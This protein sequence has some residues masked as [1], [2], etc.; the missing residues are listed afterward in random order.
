MIKTLNSHVHLGN[1]EVEF[2]YKNPSI[3]DA[4][5]FIEKILT[6]VFRFSRNPHCSKPETVINFEVVQ[7]KS[8]SFFILDR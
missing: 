1:S 3:S 2:S 8:E 4:S 6:Q 5:E 7:I